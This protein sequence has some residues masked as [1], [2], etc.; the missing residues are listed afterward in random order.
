[1][2]IFLQVNENSHTKN[3]GSYQLLSAYSVQ[4]SLLSVLYTLALLGLIL[5]TVSCFYSSGF[6]G[7]G[8]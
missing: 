2:L 5:N 1:M 7:Q 3:N 6:F 4:Y 8:H